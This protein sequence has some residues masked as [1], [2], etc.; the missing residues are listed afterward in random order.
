MDLPIEKENCPW[1]GQG[2]AAGEW[3][4]HP[5]R[6]P[7]TPITRAGAEPSAERSAEVDD[8]PEAVLLPWGFSWEV[9]HKRMYFMEMSERRIW[10]TWRFNPHHGTSWNKPRSH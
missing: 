2:F 7:V 1:P 6:W 4:C 9:T 3:Y 5:G 10:Q 8:M